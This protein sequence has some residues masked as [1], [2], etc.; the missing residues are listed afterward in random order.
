MERIISKKNAFNC[1]AIET[2][3]NIEVKYEI[4]L[5]KEIFIQLFF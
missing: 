1:I 3:W 4:K 2:A 5:R